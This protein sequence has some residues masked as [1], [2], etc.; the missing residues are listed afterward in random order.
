MLTCWL[1]AGITFNLACMLR[2]PYL[3]QS[4]STAE[5][6]AIHL[7]AGQTNIQMKIQRVKDM[8]V[9]NLH[10]N[11]TIIS[12][13]ISVETKV[14]DRLTNTVIPIATPP[15]TACMNKINLGSRSKRKSSKPWFCPSGARQKDPESS[16]EDLQLA[17]SGHSDRS[18]GADC[19]WRDLCHDGPQRDSQ[20][21]QAQSKRRCKLQANLRMVSKS[22]QDGFVCV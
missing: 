5:G 15:K 18:Q 1:L 12:L 17:A 10:I 4:Q 2:Y 14:V 9:Y 8:N 3:H 19:A 20:S 13:D 21:G 22:F 11:P 6:N 7:N 16:P